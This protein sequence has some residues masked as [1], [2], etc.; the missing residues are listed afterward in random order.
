MSIWHWAEWLTTVPK[1]HQ[2]TLGEGGTPLIHSQRL[3]PSVGL[4]NLLLKLEITN[5]TASYKD[6]FAA[7]AISHMKA[8]GQSRCIA[9]SSGNTGAS[10]AAYCAA[11]GIEC[12]IA[13]VEGAP[14]GK[15]KQ[16]LA[17]GA[18]LF[19]IRGFGI[20]AAMTTE[21]M[22]M[23]RA[24]GEEADSAAQVSAYAYSPHGMEAVMTL[25]FE[26]AEQSPQI[27]HVFC[28][29]GGGGMALA[30]ARGFSK[31]VKAGKIPK[32][33][34][35]ECAQPEGNDTIA[36]PLR[37][38]AI[39]A[40][41]VS[42]TTQISG[43]QVP[44]VI[45]GDQVIEECRATGGN[46]HV[47]TDEEVWAIQK[48]LAREEGIFAEPA[49]VLS[50]AAAVKA[51]RNHEIAPDATVVSFITAS[52]FKDPFAVDRLLAGATAPLT[53]ASDLQAFLSS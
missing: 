52:G 3:G 19:R 32:S 51:A 40:R 29:A 8:N 2:V 50:L 36:T 22:E 42:C 14:E 21:V 48:R 47:V 13:I 15:L 30:V 9:T 45:D 16:M 10:L 5:P 49:G 23:I 44:N 27:D 18:K 46:G 35:V 25:S 20:D 41:E 53:E 38:G 33:P 24:A 39:H 4:N 28:P 1:E 31:L 37:E 26:L 7:G 12:V 34:R 6:R 43:L 17:Y 11:T